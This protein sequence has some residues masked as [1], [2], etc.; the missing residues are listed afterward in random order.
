MD[1]K[2]FEKWFTDKLLLNI[3][4]NSVVVMDHA[5][6]HSVA[7]EKAP[8]KSTRKADIQ[9]W[10]TKK[11]VLWSQDMVRAQLLELSQRVNTPSIVHSGGCPWP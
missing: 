6:C 10:H 1:G 4:A 11:G 7:L 3:P 8:T 2:Y 9:V 5:P